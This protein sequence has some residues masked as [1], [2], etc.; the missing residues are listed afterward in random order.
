[1]HIRRFSAHR[2]SHC[3]LAGQT[4]QDWPERSYAGSRSRFGLFLEDEYA[5][6]PLIND[7]F[8]HDDFLEVL[9]FRQLVHDVKH[10]RFKDGTKTSR[11]CLAQERF[12]SYS[13][14]RFVRESQFHMLKSEQF[15]VLLDQRILWFQQNAN[16]RILVQFVQA[17]GDWQTP[18]EL[19][20]QDVVN[21]VL[22]GCS[23]Q[24]CWRFPHS[25]DR[26]FGR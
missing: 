20:Y 12:G 10:C 7:V 25:G 5:L 23:L 16:Q 4:A 8:V 2:L 9:E 19:P 24:G 11:A 6:L 3:V 18:Y 26:R 22:S 14:Q 1:M 21:Q 17:G 15:L 13:T